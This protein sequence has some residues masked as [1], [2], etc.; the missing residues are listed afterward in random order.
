[1]NIN[2]ETNAERCREQLGSVLTLVRVYTHELVNH[3]TV[4]L[5]ICEIARSEV[6]DPQVKEF[7]TLERI[8]ILARKMAG[9][10][11]SLATIE[12]GNTKHDA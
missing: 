4:I 2:P 8:E 7:A 10:T 6:Q 1:M 9:V 11:Y 5:S 3:L 12:S